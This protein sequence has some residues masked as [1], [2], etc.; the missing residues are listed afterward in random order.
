MTALT[1]IAEPFPDWEAAQQIA[2]ARDLARAV[3]AV[4]PRSCSA[5][6]LV[7][8]GTTAPSFD[9]PL[10]RVEAIPMPAGMLPFL[11]QSG[12]SARPLDG[13]FVHS[14]TPLAPLRSRDEDDGSQTSVAVPHS[15]AWEAPALMGNGQARL[16][17]SFVRRAVKYADVVVTATHAAARAL[18]EHYGSDLPVQV[19]PLA[20]PAEFLAGPDAAERRTALGLPPHYAVTTAAPGEHGRLDWVLDPLRADASLPP[21]VIIEGLDPRAPKAENGKADPPPVVPAELQD[22]AI[23]VQPRDLADVG[24]I[25]AGAGLL[26]QPQAYTGAGYALLGA[27]GAGLPVLHSGHPATDEIVFDAGCVAETKEAFAAE[28]ARLTHDHSDRK[29]LAVIAKDRSRSFSW[30]GTAWQLWET[31]ANL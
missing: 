14:L 29:T 17:R 5:R 15:I 24:A 20:P 25:L 27:L 18:Q 8:R 10:V 7:A 28:F 23:A 13:E 16:Y 4:A 9:S 21:V 30:E 11:W 6:Y 2:A 26:L 22:R 3:A 12:A 1:L 19:M 31:H